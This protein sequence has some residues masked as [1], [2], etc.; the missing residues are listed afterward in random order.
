MMTPMNI[1]IELWCV[2][3]GRSFKNSRNR[4]LSNGVKEK[5]SGFYGGNGHF[6]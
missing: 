2:L 3:N 4:G 6:P 5:V 1:D